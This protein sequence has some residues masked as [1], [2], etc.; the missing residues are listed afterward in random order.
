MM[1]LFRFRIGLMSMDNNNNET[2]G[3]SLY[4]SILGDATTTTVA[5]T[6]DSNSVTA[7]YEVVVEEGYV[8]ADEILN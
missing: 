8:E 6:K 2:F 4:L 5:V 1:K 3:E 7:V